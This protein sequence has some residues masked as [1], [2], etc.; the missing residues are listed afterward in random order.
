MKC[1]FLGK[2]QFDINFS[3]LDFLKDKLERNLEW[4]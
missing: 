1:I 3:L 4:K 2:S